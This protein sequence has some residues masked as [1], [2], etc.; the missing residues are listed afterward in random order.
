MLKTA[1]MGTEDFLGWIS[2]GQLFAGDDYL[3]A[4][5]LQKK[6]SG[7]F[8]AIVTADNLR[9]NTGSAVVVVD[10]RK[11]REFFAFVSTYIAEFS[12]FTAFFRVITT[13]DLG[14]LPAEFGHSLSGPKP[15]QLE[16]LVG[17]AIMEAALYTRARGTNEDAKSISLA[18]ANATYSA[19]AIQGLR[20]GP[21]VDVLSIGKGWQSLRSLVGGERLPLDLDRLIRF[22]NLVRL[23][24]YG[25]HP[26]KTRP[27]DLNIATAIRHAIENGRVTDDVL[28][29]LLS[30]A[31]EINARIPSFRGPREQKARAVQEVLNSLASLG[32]GETQTRECLAGC[33][34]SVLGDGSFKFL[35]TALSLSSSLPMAPLWFSLWSGLQPSSDLMTAFNCL[36]RRLARDLR[37][38]RDI[39]AEPVDDISLV[40]LQTASDDLERILRGQGSSLSVEIYPNVSSRQGLSRSALASTGGK[41]FQKEFREL[42]SLL[43][44]STSVLSKIDGTYSSVSGSKGEQTED[45]LSSKRKSR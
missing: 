27:E 41:D 26:E 18:A 23:S 28:E 10:R 22:W 15:R 1:V 45:K 11:V 13:D 29:E 9:E 34:L 19:A 25:D 24:L 14:L 38:R 33:L 5:A 31:P 4:S 35:P 20:L 40:E 16:K 43:A 21:M 8:C 42:R 44:Q 3:S 32:S 30:L 36:G 39:F 17:V 12:P 37:S 7:K 6:L 2:G